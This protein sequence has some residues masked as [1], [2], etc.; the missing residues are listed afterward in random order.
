MLIASSRLR[1]RSCAKLN[2]GWAYP[3]FRNFARADMCNLATSPVSTAQGVR[4]LQ[5][6]RIREAAAAQKFT[7]VFSTNSERNTPDGPS[8]SSYYQRP[9]TGPCLHSPAWGWI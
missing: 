5:T 3:F 2:Q 8:R 1:G 6:G 4:K 9:Q 7:N